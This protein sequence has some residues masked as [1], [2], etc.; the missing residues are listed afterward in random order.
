MKRPNARVTI[1]DRRLQVDVLTRSTVVEVRDYDAQGT[2]GNAGGSWTDEV[3]RDCRRYFVRHHGNLD[4]EKAIA[5]DLQRFAEDL[6]DHAG[7]EV[8]FEP[9]EHADGLHVLKINGVE[10][11][12]YP[13]GGGYDGWGKFL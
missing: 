5:R 2:T 8:N 10:Y 6:V 3:G 1:D 7:I 13:D 11:F 9:T 12:F 4:T